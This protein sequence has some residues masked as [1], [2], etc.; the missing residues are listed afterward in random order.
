MVSTSM[1][2]TP[3]LM[4]QPAILSRA[5]ATMLKPFSAFARLFVT[6]QPVLHLRKHS[7]MQQRCRIQQTHKQGKHKNCSRKMCQLGVNFANISRKPL[8]PTDLQ[9]LLFLIT[10][11]IVWHKCWLEIIVVCTNRIG[12]HF[13]GEFDLR[14]IKKRYK[15]MTF[16]QYL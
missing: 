8:P 6:R 10:N 14:G 9:Q 12:H 16:S 4:S 11:H 1:L 3:V 15:Y 2:G 13:V 5:Q 7:I